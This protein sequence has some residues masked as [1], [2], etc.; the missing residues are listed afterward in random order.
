MKRNIYDVIIS[1]GGP[2]GVAFAIELSLHGIK[3]LVLEKHDEPMYCARA[4]FLN[5]RTMEFMLRWDTCDA[6][7]K[8]IC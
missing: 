6:M 7:R 4:Q 1:G 8:K 2:S 3:T 5:P